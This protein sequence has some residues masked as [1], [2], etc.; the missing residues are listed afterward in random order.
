M[1]VRNGQEGRGWGGEG[2]KEG[3]KVEEEEEEE[4]DKLI[5][6]DKHFSCRCSPR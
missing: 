4:G 6:S 1:W 5:E 2:V 3:G